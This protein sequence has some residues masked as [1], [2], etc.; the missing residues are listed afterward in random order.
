MIRCF[1]LSVLYLVLFTGCVSYTSVIADFN[2]GLGVVST[3]TVGFDG[4]TRISVTPAWVAPVDLSQVCTFY[5]GASWQS[6]QPEHVSL[7]YKYLSG[8]DYCM[9]Y[10]GFRSVGISVNGEIQTWS[11]G[12][13]LFTREVVGTVESVDVAASRQVHTIPLAYLRDMLTADSCF[14]RLFTS[15]GYIDMDFTV[16][17]IQNIDTVFAKNALSDFVHQIDAV[18]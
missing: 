11:L 10:T 16:T 18:N 2:Q 7:E 9:Y 1:S 4:S 5:L 8:G 15:E 12:D 17:H 14:I 3:E 6:T 13:T